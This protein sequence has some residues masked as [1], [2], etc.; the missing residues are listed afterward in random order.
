[1]NFD[2][3]WIALIFLI[4]FL[5]FPSP[6]TSIVLLA[7]GAAWA[8]QAGIAP[9]RGGR[10]TL[11]GTKVTY[12][13]GQRIVTKQPTRARL[14]AVSGTQILVAIVYLALGLGMA[15]AAF[16]RFAS[17]IGLGLTV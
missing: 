12:W 8:I 13:R 3:R 14:R 4:L 15:Y 9:W 10:S 6:H 11:G 17:L 16:I 1:M 2:G 7:I 5:L